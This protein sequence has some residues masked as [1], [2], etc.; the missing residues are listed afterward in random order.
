MPQP[1]C[2]CR[3]CRRCWHCRRRSALTLTAPLCRRRRRVRAADAEGRYSAALFVQWVP[4]ALAGTA[5]E[6]EEARYV[7]HLLSILDRFAPGARA[8]GCGVFLP[9]P[10]ARPACAS[11]QGP[12]LP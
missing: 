3:H 2:P 10:A 4:Y 9:L 12:A 6:A 5:W 11:N 1:P 7:Q 8:Q